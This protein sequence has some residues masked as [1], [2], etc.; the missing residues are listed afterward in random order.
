MIFFFLDCCCYCWWWCL[1]AI[2]RIF[3]W[4][5]LHA[6]S[7]YVH[8]HT[9]LC[10]QLPTLRQ[11]LFFTNFGFFACHTIFNLATNFKF[12]YLSLRSTIGIFGWGTRV[13]SILLSLSIC[14]ARA[15]VK[16]RL[17]LNISTTRSIFRSSRSSHNRMA[18]QICA[19][20]PRLIRIQRKWCQRGN[21]LSS[22]AAREHC[23]EQCIVSAFQCYIFWNFLNIF[24]YIEWIFSNFSNT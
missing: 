2:T 17:A 8:I 12:F 15:A 3:S 13:S 6:C 1:H 24:R 9:P 22:R 19:C 7:L 11:P 4:H 16:L 5:K 23:A 18:M 10:I 20:H 14:A 21:V